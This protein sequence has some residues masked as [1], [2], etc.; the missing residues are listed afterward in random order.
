[1]RSSGHSTRQLIK[2]SVSS[3]RAIGKK[4]TSLR[5]RH[6]P[7]DF[8]DD[9]KN[10]SGRGRPSRTELSKSHSRDHQ[11]RIKPLLPELSEVCGALWP[12]IVVMM[13]QLL[14]LRYARA[15]FTL[16]I[17]VSG[18]RIRSGQKEI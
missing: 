14:Q 7:D 4:A 11:R 17:N 15:Q 9:R 2:R 13:R 5:G 18:D 6:H 16:G 3:S 8:Y 12:C 1:M 10:H